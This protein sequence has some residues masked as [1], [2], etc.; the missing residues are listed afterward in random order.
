[1]STPNLIHNSDLT[2]KINVVSI[3]SEFR[4]LS[5]RDHNTTWPQM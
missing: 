4:Q 3:S 2:S 5:S 1:L